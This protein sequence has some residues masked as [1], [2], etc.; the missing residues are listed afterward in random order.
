MPL[1]LPLICLCIFDGQMKSLWILVWWRYGPGAAFFLAIGQEA[2][3]SKQLVA[4]ILSRPVDSMFPAGTRFFLLGG[5]GD[6]SSVLAHRIACFPPWRGRRPGDIR[7]QAAQQSSDY[8]FLRVCSVV[9]LVKGEASSG[10][11]VSQ[12]AS[13]ALLKLSPSNTK[14]FLYSSPKSAPG[15]WRQ[16]RGWGQRSRA[17][18]RPR[19]HG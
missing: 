4:H 15:R 8:I 14:Q 11:Q 7:V 17:C 16:C 13:A 9:A 2:D 6:S 19:P 12:A 3:E 18:S 1:A 10:S 5:T